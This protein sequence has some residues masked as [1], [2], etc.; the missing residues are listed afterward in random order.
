[1]VSIIEITIYIKKLLYKNIVERIIIELTKKE[2]YVLRL[3]KLEENSSLK[4]R[5]LSEKINRATID[6]KDDVE[7]NSM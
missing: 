2:K 6:R 7:W 3:M 5:E 1:M 4:P